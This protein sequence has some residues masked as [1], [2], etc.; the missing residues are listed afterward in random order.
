MNGPARDADAA[1]IRPNIAY[2]ASENLS[3]SANYGLSGEGDLGCFR[4]RLVVGIFAASSEDSVAQ[5]RGE[6][7]AAF[8]ERGEV[9]M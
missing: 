8:F 6:A 2:A 9:R 4:G 7:H 1:R 5:R 3:A